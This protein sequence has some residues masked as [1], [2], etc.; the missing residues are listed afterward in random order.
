MLEKNLLEQ[1]L[2][3]VLKRLNFAETSRAAV[4]LYRKLSNME[5]EEPLRVLI[6]GAG[7]SYAVAQY[8]KHILL[9]GEEMFVRAADAL[10]PQTAIRKLEEVAAFKER[11][12]FT[13]ENYDAVIGISYSGTTPDIKEVYKVSKDKEIPFI[14]ITHEQEEVLKSVYEDA[15]IISYFNEKDETGKESGEIAM[16]STLSSILT[17][18]CL[19]D[20]ME[21]LVMRN[22]NNRAIG[23][24]KGLNISK[25]VEAI[26]IN[27]TVHVF[28]EY[29]TE[30]TAYDIKS[31]FMDAGLASV[32]IHEK[33]DFSYGEYSMQ[34][35]QKG[36]VNINLCQYKK[37]TEYD[38]KLRD[39]LQK[40]SDETEAAYIEIGSPLPRTDSWNLQSMLKTLQLLVAISKEMKAD[41]AS[42][43]LIDS[44]TMKEATELCIRDREL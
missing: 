14:L 30:P 10:F 41:F 2:E 28:C 13:E 25:I 9:K 5:D 22:I 29:E 3:L 21:E 17:F 35:S 20:H 16:A 34:Y 39:F 37:E 26:K 1:Q 11:T 19:N 15:T 38:K 18:Y 40:V 6:V 44:E 33:R 4:E 36:G 7:N 24:V 43:Q 23:F 31:K 32:V 27:P 8:A 42:K 12:G